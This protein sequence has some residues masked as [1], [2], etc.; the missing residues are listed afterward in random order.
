MNPARRHFMISVV[1]AGAAL[2]APSVNGRARA[3]VVIVGGGAGGASVARKIAIDMAGQVD[4][5]LIEPN[6]RHTTCYFS[7]LYLGGLRSFESLQHGYDGL[8][9]A[10]VDVI[11]DFAAAI[12][13]RKRHVVLAGGEHLPYDRLV[14][15]PGI[16]FVEGSVDGWTLE[17]SDRMPHA[18]RAGPQ[19][20][21]LAKMI[22]S[23]PQGGVFAM[24]APS[25][26]YRCPPGP[27]ER[28]SM[29]AHYLKGKNPTAKIIIIDPKEVFTLQKLFEDAWLKYYDGMIEW[30]GPDFGS[31]N[32]SVSPDAMEISVDGEAIKVDCCNVIPDQKAGGIADLAGLTDDSGWAPVDPFSMRSRLDNSVFVLGDSAQQGD[33]PKSA[34]SAHSQ[35]Q[36]AAASVIGDLTDRATPDPVYFN[37]C[38][39]ALAP[40]DSVKDGGTYK[41]ADGKIA[42]LGKYV[43]QADEDPAMRAATY[44]ESIDWYHTITAQI[45]G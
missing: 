43:S 3:K 28:V 12:D 39:S 42:S 14:V 32:L 19:T 36:V 18:Y 40:D 38:W 8:T 30:I 34:T 33:M 23:M 44:Q 13:R 16:D 25:E 21:L 5:T 27:Y 24:V 9:R 37:A 7:N 17:A 41:P 20:L 26:P 29:I 22:E 1:C 31:R 35:A 6:A 15:A 10:G 4:V 11:Q 45:F 2:A